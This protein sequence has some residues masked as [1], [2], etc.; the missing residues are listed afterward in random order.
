MEVLLKKYG[1]VNKVSNG[2]LMGK[3]RSPIK[4]SREFWRI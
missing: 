4:K 3:L 1:M 2:I